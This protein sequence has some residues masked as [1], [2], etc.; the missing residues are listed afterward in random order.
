[1]RWL[2]I[3]AGAALVI[4][5]L[6]TARKEALKRGKTTLASA[7]PLAGGALLCFLVAAAPVNSTVSNIAILVALLLLA[8][9]IGVMLWQAFR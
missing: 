6:S 7:L 3:I 1:M 2:R 8:S 9:S 5:L 4:W